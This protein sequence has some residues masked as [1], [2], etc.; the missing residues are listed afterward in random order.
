MRC[1]NIWSALA[2]INHRGTPGGLARA[3]RPFGAALAC[4]LTLAV[5]LGACGNKPSPPP[6]P[7]AAAGAAARTYLTDLLRWQAGDLDATKVRGATPALRD[8]LASSRRPPASLDARRRVL[9]VSPA[10]P[11][12]NDEIVTATL[13][14]D[15]SDLVYEVQLTLTRD[16][17]GRWRVRST[18]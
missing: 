5:G 10:R 14:N 18:R 15:T 13:K 16:G 12:G 11:N 4:S 7:E 8:L 6:S 1:V 3:H 17:G 9:E 2:S